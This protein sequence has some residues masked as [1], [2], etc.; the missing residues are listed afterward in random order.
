ML[1]KA[2]E[3]LADSGYVRRVPGNGNRREPFSVFFTG[4]RHDHYAQ[5]R[6]ALQPGH[7]S[8]VPG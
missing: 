6:E 3:M 1:K 4:G 5:P 7:P 8:A 2:Q